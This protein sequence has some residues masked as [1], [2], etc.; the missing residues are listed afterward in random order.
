MSDIEDGNYYE[1]ALRPDKR[2]LE[3]LDTMMEGPTLLQRLLAMHGARIETIDQAAAFL[4]KNWKRLVPYMFSRSEGQTPNAME[5]LILRLASEKLDVF[6][7]DFAASCALTTTQEVLLPI[8]ELAAVGVNDPA[9]VAQARQ[10]MKHGGAFKLLCYAKE[11]AVGIEFDRIPLPLPRKSSSVTR[12]KVHSVHHHE[13]KKAMPSHS[14]VKQHQ[15]NVGMSAQ[16]FLTSFNNRV[17]A[18]LK[19]ELAVSRQFST[20]RFADLSG[21]GVSGGLPSLPKRR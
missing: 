7:L 2:Q 4:D 3:L 12:P 6:R 5:Q 21:W 20:T 10:G 16:E 14:K 18:Q 13:T 15:K 9:G 17:T 8:P 19:Q 11:Y 1:F